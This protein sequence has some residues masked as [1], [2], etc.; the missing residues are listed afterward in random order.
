MALL[1]RN[2]RTVHGRVI[3]SER[4]A[5]Q[6]S[7][8]GSKSYLSFR[9]VVRVFEVGIVVVIVLDGHQFRI[10][11]LFAGDAFKSGKNA[12]IVILVIHTFLGG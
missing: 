8:K 12:S 2:A 10:H 5:I 3:A 7:A 11:G 4:R 9:S 1:P 6:Q